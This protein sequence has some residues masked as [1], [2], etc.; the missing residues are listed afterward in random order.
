VEEVT[1][2]MPIVQI[3]ML[4]GRDVEKKHRLI[5]M[6]TEAVCTA[7]DAEPQS[8]RVIIREMAADHYGIAGE[9]ASLRKRV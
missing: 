6:V 5:R 8:V 4:E 2:A 1:Q 7:L 3:D 9:P